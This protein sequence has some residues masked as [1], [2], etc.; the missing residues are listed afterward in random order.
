[1]LDGNAGYS[2]PEAWLWRR[3]TGRL[4]AELLHNDLF[5]LR[6]GCVTPD[7]AYSG[8]TNH[9]RPWMFA[10]GSRIRCKRDVATSARLRCASCT[11]PWNLWQFYPLPCR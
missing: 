3:D 2:M 11:S 8:P 10:S 1:M 4:A 9:V 7:L 5:H 6:S